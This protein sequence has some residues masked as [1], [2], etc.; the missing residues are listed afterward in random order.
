MAKYLSLQVKQIPLSHLNWISTSDSF[1]RVVAFGSLGS[2]GV[3]VDA[4]EDMAGSGFAGIWFNGL[5]N[6]R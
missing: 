6:N 2:K 1:L 5:G 4:G 3:M